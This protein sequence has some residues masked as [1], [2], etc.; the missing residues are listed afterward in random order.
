MT[1]DSGPCLPPSDPVE[2]MTENTLRALLARLDDLP[3][4]IRT[5]HLNGGGAGAHK[6]PSPA[7]SGAQQDELA[8]RRKNCDSGG[9]RQG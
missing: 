8:P 7:D 1:W 5:Q 2:P 3:I 9:D 4:R 6:I